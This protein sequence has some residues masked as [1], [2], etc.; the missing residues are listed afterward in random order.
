[1]T[2]EKGADWLP[3]RQTFDLAPPSGTPAP[4]GGLLGSGPDPVA[5]L[6][7]KVTRIEIAA[8]Q[9]DDVVLLYFP[10]GLTYEQV[11][12]AREAF[13]ECIDR[14]VKVIGFIGNVRVEVKRPEKVPS[15]AEQVHAEFPPP[16][17]DHSYPA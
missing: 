15:I 10:D 11:A 9:P 14:P 13:I 2:V 3:G 4:P 7:S 6:A 17:P 12:A 5:E 8:I 16:L 1:M